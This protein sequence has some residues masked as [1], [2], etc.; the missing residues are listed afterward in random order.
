MVATTSSVLGSIPTRSH[1]NCCRPHGASSDRHAEGH[2]TH[3]DDR[4]GLLREPVETPDGSIVDHWGPY[5]SEA[6]RWIA[7]FGT[8]L[9]LDRLSTPCI[10]ADQRRLLQRRP[11][12]VDVP[13]RNRGARRLQRRRSLRSGRAPVGD[14]GR[15]PRGVSHEALRVCQSVRGRFAGP[16]PIPNAHAAERSAN[17]TARRNSVTS[18]TV[19]TRSGERRIKPG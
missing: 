6:D 17:A 14:R 5:R 10:D 16:L 18:Q 7:R 1:R 8:D 19:I 2:L 11:R 12:H 3:L 9:G 15:T 13:S 4:I